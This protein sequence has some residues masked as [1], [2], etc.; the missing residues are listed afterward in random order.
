MTTGML[1]H[2][3]PGK[4]HQVLGLTTRRPNACPPPRSTP[5]QRAAERRLGPRG[6]VPREDF[7]DGAMAAITSAA[8]PLCCLAVRVRAC[9]VRWSQSR[10]RG[11]ATL[12]THSCRGNRRRRM[13]S[14]PDG[15]A[16]HA[17]DRSIAARAA[18]HLGGRDE[19]AADATAGRFL[20]PQ[21]RREKTLKYHVA[22]CSVRYGGIGRRAAMTCSTTTEGGGNGLSAKEECAAVLAAA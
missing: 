2:A 12:E 14:E 3:V 8:L 17:V 4:G 15:P 6:C 10:D 1:T 20:R 13:C 9:N 22:A 18:L 7:L 16:R 5:D 19:L 11:E 21:R